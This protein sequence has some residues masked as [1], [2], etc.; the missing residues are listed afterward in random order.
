MALM[1]EQPTQDEVLLEM[2]EIKSRLA[3]AL[4]FDIG[5]MLEDAIRRQQA[6]GRPVICPP[7]PESHRHADKQGVAP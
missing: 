1:D 2:R 6:G 4:D 3:A 7:R 5:R